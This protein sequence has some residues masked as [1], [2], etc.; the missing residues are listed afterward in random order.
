MRN[1]NSNST[2]WP[3]GSLSS[4]SSA[5]VAQWLRSGLS[6]WRAML[7]T[8]RQRLDLREL[9]DRTLRDIGVSRTDVEREASRHFWD[10]GDRTG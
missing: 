6:R 3:T 5:T 2:G 7:V 4:G 10:I 1:L 8:R 9:D